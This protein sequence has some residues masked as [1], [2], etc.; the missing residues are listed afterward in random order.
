MTAPIVTIVGIV[1]AAHVATLAIVT[2]MLRRRID[3]VIARLGVVEH[4]V[5]EVRERLTTLEVKLLGER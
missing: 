3:D 4:G 5:Q 2:M 1:S